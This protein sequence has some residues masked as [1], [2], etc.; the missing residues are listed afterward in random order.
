MRLPSIYIFL[1]L[2]LLLLPWQCCSTSEKHQEDSTTENGSDLDIITREVTIDVTKL[3]TVQTLLD[4]LFTRRSV[5]RRGIRCESNGYRM[6]EVTY[7]VIFPPYAIDGYVMRLDHEGHI[8]LNADNK[9][10]GNV[11][12]IGNYICMYVCMYVYICEMNHSY[13]H[14]MVC[15]PGCQCASLVE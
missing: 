1:V 8:L 9:T 12:I 6:E 14:C 3:N 10:R 7:D 2:S 4:V 11:E 15:C 13:L 5:C